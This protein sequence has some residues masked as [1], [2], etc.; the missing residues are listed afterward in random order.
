LQAFD[1]NSKVQTLEDT[2][3]W[4]HASSK[5]TAKFMLPGLSLCASLFSYSAFIVFTGLT[6]LE[7]AGGP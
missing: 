4:L 3:G 1:H 6:L 5:L 2:N 7:M